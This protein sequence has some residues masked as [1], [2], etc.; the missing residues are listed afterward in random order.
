ML[1]MDP[2]VCLPLKRRLSYHSIVILFWSIL[3]TTVAQSTATAA[4]STDIIIWNNPIGS[5]ADFSQTFHN[6][7]TVLVSWNAWTPATELSNSTSLVN[8]WVTSFD[9]TANQYSYKLNGSFDR[10][11]H[12][13]N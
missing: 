8:L 5:L 7:E 3:S 12:A 4:Q 2:V 10:H 13:L 1:A 6:G 11:F 9:Y